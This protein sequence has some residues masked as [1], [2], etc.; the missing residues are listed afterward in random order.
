LA[1]AIAKLA[2][3]ADLRRRF[4]TAARHLVET[5]FSSARIGREIVALYRRLLTPEALSGLPRSDLSG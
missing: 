1:E 5:E 3:D 2:G 4:G